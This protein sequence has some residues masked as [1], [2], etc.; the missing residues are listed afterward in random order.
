MEKHAVYYHTQEISFFPGR[1]RKEE[2]EQ[3]REKSHIRERK[4][5]LSKMT[6]YNTEKVIQHYN[7]KGNEMLKARCKPY[8]IETELIML[9]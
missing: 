4:L 2:K 1:K 5:A 3:V 7:V 9:A 6:P 8:V